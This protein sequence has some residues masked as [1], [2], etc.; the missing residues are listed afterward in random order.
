MAGSLGVRGLG[1]R[2]PKSETPTPIY[3]YIH[4]YIYIDMYVFCVSTIILTARFRGQALGRQVSDLG[5]KVDR[6]VCRLYCL[7]L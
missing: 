5:L 1:L 3:I 6:T 4:I 7:A 2:A